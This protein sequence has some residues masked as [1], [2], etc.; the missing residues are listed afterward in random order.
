MYQKTSLTVFFNIFMFSIHLQV[1]ISLTECDLST[2]CALDRNQFDT[3]VITCTITP[4]GPTDD[5]C[6]GHGSSFSNCECVDP[7]ERISTTGGTYW[8]SSDGNWDTGLYMLEWYA[9]CYPDAGPNSI[10][11]D[12]SGNTV[13][14]V[15]DGD[16]VIY[17]CPEGYTG[18]GTS[19][20]I[21]TEGEWEPHIPFRCLDLLFVCFASNKPSLCQRCLDV[22]P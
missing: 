15:Q 5:P 14:V 3:T 10:V 19:K 13:T 4:S 20:V 22:V 9:P 12:S 18:D 11:Q 8:C 6:Y 16:Y 7:N 1:V 21:C 2:Q 17:S